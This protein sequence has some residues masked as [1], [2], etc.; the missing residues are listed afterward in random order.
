M[1]HVAI[2]RG[3]LHEV[4]QAMQ[5]GATKVNATTD[6]V[7]MVMG[8]FLGCMRAYGFTD[9]EVFGVMEQVASQT[10]MQQAIPQ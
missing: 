5:G 1:K 10:T 8:C 4:F 6:E 9:E 7:I 2:K 3:R